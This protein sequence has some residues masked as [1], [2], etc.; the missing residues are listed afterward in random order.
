MLEGPIVLAEGRTRVPVALL[1]SWIAEALGGINE[2]HLFIRGHSARGFK[3][4]SM[5]LLSE[6]ELEER[7]PRAEA[8]PGARSRD[9]AQVTSPEVLA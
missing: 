6:V 3:K 9:R 5:A 4:R 1:E 7:I 8:R 2:G